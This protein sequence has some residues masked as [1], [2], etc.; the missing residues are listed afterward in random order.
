M[1]RTRIILLIALLGAAAVG[2]SSIRGATI[3][4]TEVGDGLGVHTNLRQAVADANDGDTIEFAPQ[5]GGYTLALMPALGEL[6]VN[7][8]V[9]INWVPQAG[10]PTFLGVSSWYVSRVFHISPGKTVTISGLTIFNGSA[11]ASFGGGIYNDHA[12]L[13]VN[14]CTISGNSADQGTGGGIYN[15]GGPVTINSTTVSGNSAWPGGGIC[16]DAGTM[17]INNSTVSGNTDNGYNYGGG[18]LNFGTLTITNSTLSGNSAYAG[19][20]IYNWQ[21]ATLTI[22]NTTFS[23]NF[24]GTGSYANGGGINNEDGT[25]NIGNTIFKAGPSGENIYHVHY[26]AGSVTSLGYNLSSD[27][28]GGYLT[29][30]GDRI[31]TDPKLGPLQNN[32]GPTFTHL[33]ASDSPAIDG[34]DPALSMDQ[35]GPGFAR[36]VNGRADI[37][38]VEVQA[39]PSPTPTPTATPRPHGRH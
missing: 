13:T 36:V 15:N 21:G 1:K 5:L 17:T 14:N 31:N 11:T 39:A 38:A 30:T 20:G 4:V 22:I 3:T 10:Y 24:C 16:N 9:T 25:V 12:R 37:G 34:A 29:A 26:V 19:G 35:R 2:L 23:G 32:G 28:G 33:P 8:S 27:D 7:K 6:V 18:I